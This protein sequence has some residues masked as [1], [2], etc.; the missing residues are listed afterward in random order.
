MNAVIKEIEINIECEMCGSNDFATIDDPFNQDLV[1][2]LAD[3]V[4]E[5]WQFYQ[6]SAW[7]ENPRRWM[8]DPADPK[9][10]NHNPFRG[11]LAFCCADC[12]EEW[13]KKEKEE[14]I[15]WSLCTNDDLSSFV[16]GDFDETIEILR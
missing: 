14:K 7:S 9:Y 12:F 13:L 4:T 15:D 1:E 5:G 10:S 3:A 8:R 11:V 16:A 6:D 2:T